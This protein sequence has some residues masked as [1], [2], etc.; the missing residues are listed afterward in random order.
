MPRSRAKQGNRK[1]RQR[2]YRID[3][4]GNRRVVKLANGRPKTEPIPTHPHGSAEYWQLRE[5]RQKIADF[6]ANIREEREAK[7]RLE[8]E[9]AAMALVGAH[10]S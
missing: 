1:H 7:A 3:E 2:V 10:P 6:W 4:N 8:D 5:K 9:A